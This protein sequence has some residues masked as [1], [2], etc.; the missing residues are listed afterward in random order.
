[1]KKLNEKGV[2]CQLNVL[3]SGSNKWLISLA[4]KLNIKEKIHFDGILSGG[5]AVSEWLDDKDIYIQPSLTEGLPRAL[6]EAMS[7]GLPAVGSSVG[8]IPELLSQDYLHKPGSLE[9]L[10]DIVNLFIKDQELMKKESQV[11]FRKSQEY[12]KDVLMKR[13]DDFWKE[14]IKRE[15]T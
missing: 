9:E 14:F 10:L 1:V 7:R 5:E 3:G 6:I 13:R 11:N 12:T 15:V 2:N 4:D 8:G